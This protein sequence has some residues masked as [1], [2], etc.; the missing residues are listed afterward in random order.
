QRPHCRGRQRASSLIPTERTEAARSRRRLV[1]LLL[2]LLVL[3]FLWSGRGRSGGSFL[4]ARLCGSSGGGRRSFLSGAANDG[5]HGE[6]SL[7]GGW[8]YAFRP[9]DRRNVDAV[10]DLEAGQIHIEMLGDGVGRAAD[11]NFVAHDVQDT[12]A[13][14][15][16]GGG[17][18]QEAHRNLD[19][20]QRM[21]AHAHEI[22]MDGNVAN[23]IDLHLAGDD[24]R[25]GSIQV[26][27]ENRALKVTGVELL[28]DGPVVH[29]DDLWRRLVAIQDSGNA[30]LTARRPC[31]AFAGARPRPG[32]EF[33]RLSHEFSPIKTIKGL[34]EAPKLNQAPGKRADARLRGLINGPRSQ[35]NQLI[36]P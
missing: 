26:E 21:L 6:V 17:F 25:F 33:Q 22:A 9:L 28:R 10:T 30:P 11:R 5:R 16:G 2:L 19:G 20:D 4:S 35:D 8:L 18:V 23:V 7:G 1:L 29:V 36:G 15:A 24:A 27:Y 3:V 13:L 34:R 14:D 31:A 32:L 12:A